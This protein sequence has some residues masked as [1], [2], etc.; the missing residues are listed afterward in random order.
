MYD[1]NLMVVDSFMMGHSD[2]LLLRS[3]LI[4]LI[5]VYMYV[6][7]NFLECPMYRPT[8]TCTCVCLHRYIHTYNKMSPYT[9]VTVITLSYFYCQ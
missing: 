4:K 1:N 3:L 8:C 7:K 6:V 9:V 2:D 5:T